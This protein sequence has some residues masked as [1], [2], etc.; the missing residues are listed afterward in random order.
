MKAKHDKSVRW[1]HVHGRASSFLLLSNDAMMV[2]MAFDGLFSPL[3][4]GGMFLPLFK[5]SASQV[6]LS[7]WKAKSRAA[8]R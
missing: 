8:E 1:K 5:T 6:Y 3:L 7:V 2:T 4:P